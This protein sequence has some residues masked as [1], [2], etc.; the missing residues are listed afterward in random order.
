M[1]IKKVSLNYM[2]A[3]TKTRPVAKVKVSSAKLEELDYAI[4]GKIEQNKSSYNLAKEN[5][6]DDIYRG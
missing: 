3:V 6:K 5:L 4:K 2:S 1:S